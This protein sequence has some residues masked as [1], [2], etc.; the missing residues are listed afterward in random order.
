MKKKEQGKNLKG[1]QQTIV[2]FSLFLLVICLLGILFMNWY[3]KQPGVM[4]KIQNQLAKQMTYDQVKEGEEKTSS[5]YV[6]FDA[7]FLK[8][9]NGDGTPEKVRGT[10]KEVFTDDDLY[11]EL[12]VKTKGYL[13]DAQIDI[14]KQSSRNYYFNTEL[15]ADSQI[16]Q[17][18]VAD[19]T[20]H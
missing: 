19:D 8:D 10:C 13:K 17:D 2:L 6:T 9:L 16:K 1:K 20:Q 3:Q 12:N 4:E 5:D 15:A 18:Y 14:G 11:L 7:F